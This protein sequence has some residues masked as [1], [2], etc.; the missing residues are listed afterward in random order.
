MCLTHNELREDGS[1]LDEQKLMQKNTWR[2]YFTTNPVEAD[3]VAKDVS[4][5]SGL[6]VYLQLLKI[7]RITAPSFSLSAGKRW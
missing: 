6:Q 5:A 1:D 4:M 2:Y 3:T 7:Y